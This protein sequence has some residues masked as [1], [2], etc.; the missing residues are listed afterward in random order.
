MFFVTVF[1][2]VIL[3]EK[4]GYQQILDFL[5]HS[6]Y[7]FMLNCYF[8]LNKYFFICKIEAKVI[9]IIFAFSFLLL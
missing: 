2:S 9:E 8:L 1:S 5:K 7:I 3:K 4:I 6:V